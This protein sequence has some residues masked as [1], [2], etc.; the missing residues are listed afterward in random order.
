MP[1]TLDRVVTCGATQLIEAGARTADGVS[2]P[3]VIPADLVNSPYRRHIAESRGVTWTSVAAATMAAAE[4][5]HRHRGAEK[6]HEARPACA[7]FS[8]D[9]FEAVETVCTAAIEAPCREG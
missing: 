7:E 3:A 9:V 5:D 2:E 6:R 4:T 1:G 8:D